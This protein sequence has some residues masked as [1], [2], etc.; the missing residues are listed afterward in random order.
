MNPD[1]KKKLLR[2][3]PYGLY[4]IGVKS[5]DD[6]HGLTG[7]W[8]TQVSMNPPVI[9]IG[10][11]EGTKS[12]EMIKQGK[13]LTVNFISKGGRAIIEHFFKSATREGN[14]LGQYAFH[15]GKTGA[16]ILDEAIGCLE[17]EVK[18]IADGFGDHAIVIAEVVEADLPSD[19][20][21]LVMSDTPWHYGG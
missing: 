8:L 12:L 17:C 9:A 19:A 16:P 4:V 18:Q 5:G 14:R 20:D 11:R 7:S 2:K 15:T 3:I 21:S 6:L 10:I 1:I 13:V